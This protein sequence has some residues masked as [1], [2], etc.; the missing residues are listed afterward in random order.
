MS[1][2]R[3]QIE[4]EHYYTTQVA[5]DTHRSM[6]YEELSAPIKACLERYAPDPR[7]SAARRA[8]EV[9]CISNRAQGAWGY[10]SEESRATWER[11]YAV[12]PGLTEEETGAKLCVP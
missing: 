11:W 7:W 4:Y 8:Y 2:T 12:A 10:L 6:P 9:Y 5:L 1:K 3:G